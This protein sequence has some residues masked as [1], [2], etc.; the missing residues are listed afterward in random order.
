LK[1][2]AHSLSRGEAGAHEYMNMTTEARKKASA[3]SPFSDQPPHRIQSSPRHFPHVRRT[4]SEI[5]ELIISI[6]ASAHLL[7][8][9]SL[10]DYPGHRLFDGPHQQSTIN[11]HQSTITNYQAATQTS[12]S[13]PENSRPSRLPPW[14]RNFLLNEQWTSPSSQ[15]CNPSGASGVERRAGQMKPGT[16][17]S[18]PDSFSTT[19]S[20]TGKGGNRI[21]G[22]IT[23]GTRL[24]MNWIDI[25]KGGVQCTVIWVVFELKVRGNSGTGSNGDVHHAQELTRT[26]WALLRN[27]NE[28]DFTADNSNNSN[29]SNLQL[30][31]VRPA[32]QFLKIGRRHI[33][34]NRA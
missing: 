10:T 4:D 25:V 31:E 18:D 24:M 8:N 34:T 5:W 7:G 16:I 26:K 2:I 30:S 11:N 32:S 28:F 29:Y 27:E 22:S 20:Q 9:G 23:V 12:G 1:V 13:K 15:D 3:L 14:I 19:F 17:R 21:W 6:L 33:P